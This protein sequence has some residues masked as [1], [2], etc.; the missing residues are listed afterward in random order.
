MWT[1][2]C[3][4]K[5]AGGIVL[6]ALAIVCSHCTSLSGCASQ[7][8]NPMSGPRP[9]VSRRP[10]TV[11]DAIE[12]T[13]FGD[14]DYLDGGSGRHGVAQFAPD[15]KRFVIVLKRGNLKTNTNEYSL[16]LFQS[17][18]KYE[19][20]VPERLVSFSSSSKRPGIQEV[21]WLDHRSLAFLGENPGEVQQLY[22]VDC[23]TKQ[24]RKLTKH[25]T[26]VISYAVSTN[27]DRFFFS[28]EQPSETLLTEKTKREGI[29]VSNH[30]LA[31]LITLRTL[32]RPRHYGEL[33]A[34]RQ[35]SSE[36]VPVKTRGLIG[37]WPLWLSPDSR[38]LILRTYL[39]DR[40]PGDWKSY[41]DGYLQR[42]LC[43]KHGN[44]EPFIIRQFELVDVE[45]LK[46]EAL[47][48]S[49]IAPPYYPGMAAEV[50]WSADS[51]SVVVSGTYLPLKVYS[52]TERKRRQSNRF[53]AEIRIPSRE[54]VP[55][56]LGDMKLS[57]WDSRT[58]E[59]VL[60]TSTND[61][62]AARKGNLIAFKR[63]DGAWK[64]VSASGGD[65]SRMDKIDVTLNEDLNTPPKIYVRDNRTRQERVLL[66]LNPQFHDFQ[67]GR[68]KDVSYKA[69]DGH[70]VSAGLYFPPHYIRDRR[71]PLVIQTHG[72]N[73]ERFWI[74]GAYSTGFAAQPL[75]GEGF[76]VLQLDEDLSTKVSTPDE[77]T[78]EMAAYE[79]AIDYLDGLGLID[80][81]RVGII[82]FSRTGIGVEYTLTHSKYHSAAATLADAS[83]QGYF[84]YV[85]HLNQSFAWDAEGLHG[86]IPFGRRGLDSWARSASGFNLDK[87]VTPIRIEVNGLIGVTG[88]WEQ[89]GGLRRLGKPVE[90]I[91]L[92]DAS[93]VVVKPW[94]MLISEQG[95][96][97][98]FCFWL[99]G[100]EDPDPAKA[101]QYARWR[102][103]R[104]L[105]DGTSK[106]VSQ[107]TSN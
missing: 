74:D 7:H 39:L 56:T 107:C 57:R 54:V 37:S 3:T 43:A 105:Q 68:V 99:K 18:Q 91:Y 6:L 52:P 15:G 41:E 29:V 103:L 31:E 86:G 22:T 51:Q 8:D 71:Y 36:E 81:E 83:G 38:Y 69:S 67:F 84:E 70:T 104:Q 11:A 61:S 1:R 53:V 50:L 60:Q 97:D 21:A 63:T 40:P 66:D 58:G 47:L 55:I 88:L 28:A 25:L 5:K 42:E 75:A 13:E 33:F 76:V 34:G 20:S 10:V 2:K 79:G 26:S 48:D 92:P 89:F 93:H 49:P 32:E 24:V 78:E 77:A 72:W 82:A 98:W 106:D 96:V 16:L 30:T 100:E 65:L 19:S 62:T 46:S 9:E 23:D 80:R 102:E 44:G 87:V 85:A 14:P 95:N 35:S 4:G 27:G 59:L 64:N 12:M 17:E 45:S 101:E 73:P 90:F 94:E